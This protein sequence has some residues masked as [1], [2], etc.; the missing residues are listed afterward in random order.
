MKIAILTSGILPIPAVQG[1]AV[2]NLIDYYLEYNNQH[3]LHDITV[4]SIAPPYSTPKA[5]TECTHYHYVGTTSL[6]HRLKRAWFVR[7]AAQKAGYYSPYIEYFLRE[8]MKHIK[9]QHFDAIILENRPG[10]ALPL[11]EVTDAKLIVHLHNDFLNS[12]SKQAKAIARACHS[13]ITVSDFIKQR[14]ETV[15]S[16]QLKVITVHNGINLPRF[17]QATPLSRSSLGFTDE[18]FIVVYSGRI[19]REKGV[20]ELIQAFKRLKDYPHIK[21]MVIGGSFF[22]NEQGHDPFIQSLQA[23]AEELSNRII[24]TGYVPYEQIPSYLKMA[25]VAAVPSMWDDPFPTTI[26]EAMAAGLPIVATHSGGIKESCGQ[27]AIIVEKSSVIEG[28]YISLLNLYNN[29]SCRTSMIEKGL[30]I[31][32][33]YAKERYAEDFFKAIAL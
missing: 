11:S 14:V 5:D 21:L 4:Y 27:C 13:V 6:F 15:L 24:F 20:K 7:R 22:G 23:E 29:P 28:L 10:Y 9:R 1:G 3:R 33:Q 31:S 26:L 25:D 12:E 2:E 18:D 17:Y 16:P 32:K 8:A 19:N 30:S